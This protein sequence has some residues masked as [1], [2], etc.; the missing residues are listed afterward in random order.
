MIRLPFEH[1]KYPDIDFR[2]SPCEIEIILPLTVF[3]DSFAIGSS[4]WINVC[5]IAVMNDMHI[6]ECFYDFETAVGMTRIMI[7]IVTKR[8]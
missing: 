1:L 6:G 2:G 5:N 4:S 7:C 3:K 8:Y